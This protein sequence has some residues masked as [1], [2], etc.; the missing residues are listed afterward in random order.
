LL[1]NAQYNEAVAKARQHAETAK[2]YQDAGL[3]M[4]QKLAQA[5]HKLEQ[6]SAWGFLMCMGSDNEH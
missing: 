3:V 1:C 4:K 2:Q 6:V 5:R